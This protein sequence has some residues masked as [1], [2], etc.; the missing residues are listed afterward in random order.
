MLLSDWR[1]SDVSPVNMDLNKNKIYAFSARSVG[2]KGYLGG[3]HTWYG[4]WSKEQQKW[5]VIELTDLESLEIQK[6]EV[7]FKT[8]NDYLKL[9]PFI[10]A[11]D[12]RGRWFGA[13]PKIVDECFGS[14]DFSDLVNYCKLYP[15][16]QYKVL[17]Q[18]CNSFFSFLNFKF[19]QDYQYDFKKPALIV[20]Y[21]KPEVW[22]SLLTKTAK[23]KKYTFEFNTQEVQV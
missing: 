10:V 4:F 13:H 21:K 2:L 12:P 15:F 7:L 18:N 19:N 9:S 3:S 16:E 22:Q 20:G 8:T 5:L 23:P 1:K 11:R 14:L 6:A 17:S